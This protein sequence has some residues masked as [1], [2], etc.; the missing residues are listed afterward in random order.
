M[1]RDTFLTEKT[2]WSLCT[3]TQQFVDTVLARRLSSPPVAGIIIVNPRVSQT[4]QIR[5]VTACVDLLA[6]YASWYNRH[7][8]SRHKKLNCVITVTI[9][10]S[11]VLQCKEL[12]RENLQDKTLTN[13]LK[14]LTR[15]FLS[16]RN[17]HLWFIYFRLLSRILLSEIL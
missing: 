4:S 5:I 7:K 11:C 2:V 13:Y 15:I 6:Q 12:L 8:N 10:D 3:L 1:G 9:V 14:L 17:K 16:R